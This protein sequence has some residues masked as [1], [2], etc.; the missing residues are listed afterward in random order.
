MAILL[1]EQRSVERFQ[2]A[3]GLHAKGVHKEIFL[4]YSWKLESGSELCREILSE[5]FENPR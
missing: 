4:I 1:E 3:E 2:C 5:T